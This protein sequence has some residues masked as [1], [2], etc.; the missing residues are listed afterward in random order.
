MNMVENIILRTCKY[1]MD[2]GY[3]IRTIAGKDQKGKFFYV[4]VHLTE[5]DSIVERVTYRNPTLANEK[6]VEF[7][8]KYAKLGA[9]SATNDA[10]TVTDIIP[11]AINVEPNREQEKSIVK[12][13]TLPFLRDELRNGII[14]SQ[15]VLRMKHEGVVLYYKEHD[16]YRE[17][18]AFLKSVYVDGV[19]DNLMIDGH[20]VGYE[21]QDDGLL[22]WE[23]TYEARTAENFFSWHILQACIGSLIAQNAYCPTKTVNQPATPAKR[24]RKADTNDSGQLSL[25]DF[26]GSGEPAE[27][28]EDFISSMDVSADLLNFSVDRDTEPVSAI[29]SDFQ[30]ANGNTLMPISHE[31]IKEILR[32]GGGKRNSRTRI[33]AKYQQGKTPEEMVEFLQKEYGE[34]GKGFTFGKTLN[35]AVWFDKNG[36]SVHSGT[37]AKVPA[38]S[39]LPWDEAETIIRKMVEE[40]TYMSADEVAAIREIECMRVSTLVNHFIGDLEGGTPEELRYLKKETYPT[41]Y[42]LLKDKLKTDEGIDQIFKVVHEIVTKLKSGELKLRFR[43]YYS[44]MDEILDDLIGLRKIWREFPIKESIVVKDISFITQD[45]IDVVLMR[46]SSYSNGKK[47]VYDHFMKGLTPK[48]NINFLRH[49]YGIGGGS[50]A[51]PGCDHSWKDYSGKGICLRKGDL[52]VPTARVDL[53]YTVVEKRIRELIKMGRYT[54]EPDTVAETTSADG[55]QNHETPAVEDI[56]AEVSS[57]AAQ[58]CS[59]ALTP[60]SDGIVEAILRTGGG[61]RN[62][63]SRIYAKYQQR[64]NPEEMVEFLKKEYGE[65]GKGFTFSTINIAAWFDKNGMNVYY[66]MSAMVPDAK[67]LPWN[68]VEKNIRKMVR[69]GT[70]MSADEIARVK[71][72]E[73]S[74]V[75]D[76]IFAK[77]QHTN[78]ALLNKLPCLDDC[79]YLDVT[80]KL[81]DSLM[82]NEGIENVFK[83]I[84]DAADRM[85][86]GELENRYY[87]DMTVI[88]DDLIDLRKEWIEFPSNNDVIVKEIGF[89]TQDE[90][91]AALVDCNFTK[92]LITQEN[93]KFL[94]KE[95]CTG[96]ISHELSGCDDSWREYHHGGLS[97]TKGDSQNPIVQT[98]LTQSEVE[99]RIFELFKMGRYSIKTDA[100]AEATSADVEQQETPVAAGIQD[101]ISSEAAQEQAEEP[102]TDRMPHRYQV[103]SYHHIENGFDDK[104]DYHTL[105]EAEKAA[106]GYVD[107]TMDEDGFKYDGAAVYD[108]QERKCIRI[109]GDYPDEKAIA[110]VNGLDWQAIQETV[111]EGVQDALSDLLQDAV[112]DVE[113]ESDTLTATY[114]VGDTVYLEDTA[115]IINEIG[116]FDI[117][118]SD[119]TMRYPIERAESKERFDALLKQDERNTHFFQGKKQ[120]PPKKTADL[121]NFHWTF[122][123]EE[124]PE[125]TS[126]SPKEKFRQNV[127][128]IKALQMIESENRYATP[129][130]QEILSK[131]VG[132]GGLADAFDETKSSWSNEY[133]ELKGLLSPDEY[134]SARASTLSAHYT[135]PVIIKHIYD[136]L[137]KFGFRGG[138]ILEPAMGIGRF[139]ALLPEQMRNSK[140]YGVELDSISGRIAKQLYPLADIKVCGFEE[141]NF[142]NNFFDVA[143][144]NVPFGDFKVSDR[145]Y[146]KHNFLIHDYFFAKAL[147]K[148]RPGGIVIFIT[149]KG[150]MDKKNSSVR[151]Y[152]GARAELLGAIR[153]PNTAFKAD[154]NTEVTSDILFLKK[155]DRVNM[156]EPDWVNLART[157]DG[158][159]INRYFALFSEMI[160]G[161]MEMVS[162]PYGM[163]ATCS[164][165][166]DYPLSTLLNSAVRRIEG[167]FEEIEL[168]EDFEGQ[169]DNSIPADPDVKDFSFT[170]VKNEGSAKDEVYFREGS[171]MYPL[172]APLITENRIR[173]MIAL[174]DCVYEL[175]DAQ[176]LGDTDAEINMKQKQL[177]KLYDAFTKKFGLLTSQGNKRAFDNDG[178]YPVLSA[179]EILDDE[180]NFIGKADMFHKRTINPPRIITSVDTANEAFAVSL[181]ERGRIDFAYMSQL[182]GK[183]ENE[184]LEELTG[185]IF[186]NPITENWEPA[187]EY[188]SGTVVQKLA[189]AKKYAEDDPRFTVNV[190]ALEQVQPKKLDA[191]EIEVRLGATWVDT[192]YIEDFIRDT[193]RTSP[194]VLGNTLRVFYNNV[195]G[196]WNI[197]GKSKDSSNPVPNNTYGTSRLN[198]YELL[199]HCL[200]LHDAKVYDYLEDATGKVKAVVNKAETLLAITKQE[201]IKEAF[202][203]WV[204]RDQKRRQ[205]LCEKYNAMFNTRR[206][207]EFDGSHLQFHGMSPDIEMKPHQKNA[208]ARILYGN[209]TLLAHCVGAGKTFEMAA[210]AMELRYLGLCNKP[211]FVVPN[212]LTEQWAS[213]FLRLYP[214]A[215]ILATRQKDFETKNRRRFCSRIA[216]GDYDAIIIGHSQFEKIPISAERQAL[217]LERQIDELNCAIMAAERENGVFFSVKQMESMKKKLKERLDRLN[218]DSR[219]DAAITFEQLGV[220]QLFVD[221]SHN[222]KNLFL[223]TKMGNV[224]GVQT[225]E[226]KKSTDMFNKC[227][228]LDEITGGRGITFATGTPL[229]NS[230]TELYTNMRYL[231][232]DTLMNLGLGHF[233][234]WASTFGETRTVVELAPEG[235]GYQAKTRF[236]RFYNLPELIALFKES[237]DIQTAEMLDLPRPKADYVDVLLKASDMQRELVQELGERA[238]KIRAGG[239]DSSEDNMLR[240]TNDGR[241]LALDQRLMDIEYGENEFSKVNACVKNALKLW[242]ETK[243]Q[244]GAQLI[245][246]DLSTPKNNGEF[247][248]YDDIRNKLLAA[249][250]PADEI[251]FIHEANTDTRK[252]KLFAK[253][254]MG[255]VRFLLGSTAKMGAG[256]NVQDRL[257]ALH[258]LDVPWRPSDIE[259]REGR[260][261]RQGNMNDTVKI[262]RYITENTFD[263]YSW[264]II[265]NKQ[266]FISQIMTDKS[267]VRSAEDI[268]EATLNYAEVKALA[269]GNPMIKEKMDLDVQVSRLKLFKANFTS[270]K[271][272]LEDDIAFNF[273]MKIKKLSE[274][275]EGYKAD[276]ALYEAN[277]PSIN[278]KFSI[279]LGKNEFDNR[280]EAGT[281][282]REYCFA[283]KKKKMDLSEPVQIGEF[284]GFKLLVKKDFGTYLMILRGALSHI[285]EIKS[286]SVGDMIRLEHCLTDMYSKLTEDEKKLVYYQEQLENAKIEVQKPFP[287]EKELQEKQAR[288][289]ELNAALNINDADKAP[290]VVG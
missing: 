114:K 52:T 205:A 109:Y 62:S 44:K 246:C 38:A 54:I 41:R 273:P 270:Q 183:G 18:A 65:T 234:S 207:R 50:N 31:T 233:D 202:K 229:S 188:L 87:D 254:R 264:Q 170:L 215:K 91:D 147:D 226:A 218:D 210:A 274:W 26:V 189:I 153:L 160:L 173:G 174:R 7:Q 284:M 34:T 115:F 95:S 37:A 1:P 203:D 168:D 219:K 131:Y 209:N 238:E 55:E 244:K 171:K 8:K 235:T 51:L 98:Q 180:G 228:Y 239:V 20:C 223:Y 128:A 220:D 139:F 40:G 5:D 199:E 119:P 67:T 57:E 30:D 42:E 45:E 181:C 195:T 102:S 104:L 122:D 19:K 280:N 63:R 46:G 200:N 272:R 143:I 96:Y 172:N 177:N 71:E 167:Q 252:A 279:R 196:K 165:D 155:R 48:E 83:V 159:E 184:L 204:F 175:I 35:I 227:Q 282:I 9:S 287:K 61:R 100:V 288:L 124:E 169:E 186:L 257:V 225:T 86:N 157:A 135:S 285:A 197:S 255:R 216:T 276:I 222:Y 243:H 265:E 136:A 90:I 178:S 133:L 120:E 25:F 117:H 73:C 260:I 64:K 146:N 217:M 262:F 39:I 49:E 267:P 138:N 221:E 156:E 116:M 76:S 259:Q 12:E 99:K 193:F 16:D 269:T 137:D 69:N 75:A 103:T 194:L 268:D 85:K 145:E 248:V 80:K 77:L 241:K 190:K 256:T 232:Y 245:F 148:V 132:W 88:L 154:A 261:L 58:N 53:S 258:H 66:G 47:R 179:L 11:I 22:L 121:V 6:Y 59:K 4:A 21:K 17:R 185:V 78:Q 211:M 107:G 70:Y 10:P 15:S 3:I 33:Y 13:T 141:T 281:I 266:R 89:I 212:H 94:Q 283:A 106:Q 208:V 110:Q 224:A 123:P 290:A 126:F 251:A 163:Q 23:G 113:A 151:K 84:H 93:I 198:G 249:G 127:A 240:I 111:T 275:V 108:K 134:A 68:E 206:P 166:P 149:S 192:K 81:T 72:I 161:K 263:S 152:I 14:C 187:D 92:V 231:Q 27:S 43:F 60:V 32:T 164:P 29:C 162:G 130:E 250:V 289:I 112:P 97:L 176:M 277:K 74:R 236:A 118:L 286:N 214:G 24:P 2:S 253:V 278:D 56:Q 237:A 36:M 28:M 242:N 125:G 129:V 144:G 191:S 150:T 101:E 140:L 158:I 230:M 182:T 247:N 105:E 213:E 142:P 201:T 79:S 82:T 271:Y